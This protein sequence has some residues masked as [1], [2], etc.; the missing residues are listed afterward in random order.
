[1]GKK[2]KPTLSELVIPS[3]FLKQIMIKN[4]TTTQK[5]KDDRARNWT[6]VL[7]PESAPLNWLSML[8]ELKMELVISPLHDKDIENDKPKKPHHH[9]AL[10]FEGKK[11]YEQILAITEM[12]NA[13]IPKR[14]MS[15]KAM[16]RY[17]CHLDSPDKAQYKQ[18]DLKSFGGVD[19]QEL[20]KPT[21]SSRYE[22]IAEM[23]D[24]IN[25]EEITEFIT[26]MLFAK[27]ERYETWFPILC[28]SGAFI[29]KEI[30]KSNR[31]KPRKIN[32]EDLAKSA[33]EE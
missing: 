4:S 10:L 12:F 25:E 3:R 11:S 21:S 17:F 18:S 13:P 22:L 19:L 15:I 8:E 1:M 26:F 5:R 20:L 6:F 30:I 31:H 32:V 14:I 28:D 16:I 9:I 7:Y 29:I 2:I 33:T 23:I 27:S 24:Y